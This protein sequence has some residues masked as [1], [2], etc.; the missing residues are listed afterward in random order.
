MVDPTTVNTSLSIPLR[1]ADVGTW[2]LPANNNFA[3]ID[4]MFGGVTT[5]ALS[6]QNVVLLSSQGQNAVIKFTGTILT[7][8]SITLPSIYK[9][10]TI[11][12]QV[13]NSPSS[14][15]AQLVSTSGTFGLGLA[16]GVNDVYYDGTNIKYRNMGKLGEYWDYSGPAVPSWVSFCSIPPWLNCNGTTFSSAFYPQLANHLGTTTLPDSRGR[17]RM[18]L[19]Q[20]TSRVTIGINGDVI[21]AVGGDQQLQSH[22]HTGSGTTGAVSADHTHTGSGTTSGVSVDHTHSVSGVMNGTTRLFYI[23]GAE[24]GPYTSATTS[25]ASADHSHFYSFTT[26]GISVNHTHTY[27]FT[28]ATAGTGGSQNIQPSYVGG[29][30]MIRAG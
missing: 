20:G 8:V 23:G 21:F 9:G 11:D 7:N 19:N 25:G 27:S 18:A 3:A 2:D 1:G 15:C 22:T 26:G 14:F 6:S 30:T 5:I 28:T 12:H 4:S 10:W 16:P 29:V 24:G 17:V 13:L